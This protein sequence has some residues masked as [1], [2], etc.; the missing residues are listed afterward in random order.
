MATWTK[1]V[2]SSNVAS[3][4]YDDET[5]DLIITWQKGR[6]RVSVYEGVDE[7]TAERL[8]KAPSVGSMLNSEIKPFYPHR[9]A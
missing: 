8:A 4:G 3:V 1:E 9:Y 6:N 5:N 2:F 7:A